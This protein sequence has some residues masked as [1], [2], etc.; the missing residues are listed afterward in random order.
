MTRHHTG[1]D[2]MQK[3]NKTWNVSLLIALGVVLVLPSSPVY[4]EETTTQTGESATASAGE[5]A[6]ASA[7]EGA[8][9]SADKITAEPAEKSIGET[10]SSEQSAATAAPDKEP[11][12][13]PT[14]SIHVVRALLTSGIENRE[15]TD[16][17]V[18]IS[19]NQDRIY[20]FTEFTDLK[21]K[22]I[23]H[24]WEHQGKIMGEVNFNVGSNQWRCYSSKNL[25]P[26]WT[27]IWTVSVIDENNNV[28]VETYFEVTE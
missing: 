10:E 9:V 14:K 22:L 17:I 24:R 4:S 26:E 3:T 6:A 8:A 16:E 12:T 27:G 11:A 28:L 19:K 23:K 1:K 18:S 20:F 25:L 2:K 13:K 7:A 15:P 21:G 5:S